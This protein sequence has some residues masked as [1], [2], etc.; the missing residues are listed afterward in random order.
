MLGIRE[1]NLYGDKSYSALVSFVKAKAKEHGVKAK[2]FQ[3][4]CEGKIV[5]RIQRAA[6]RYDGIIVNAGAYTHTSIAILDA[7]KAADIP[8]VEVHLTDINA[9]EDYRKKSFVSEYAFA[10][11]TGKGF[12]GYAEAITVLKKRLQ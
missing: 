1:K 5:T 4:N 7:L 12:N 2:C 9:R 3:S 6:G 8:A 11:I 10:V